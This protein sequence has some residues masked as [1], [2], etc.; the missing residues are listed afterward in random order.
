MYF[1]DKFIRTI[2]VE[3][4]STQFNGD[5][6]ALLSSVFGEELVAA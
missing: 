6:D 5:V 2:T 3:L 1:L 4:S